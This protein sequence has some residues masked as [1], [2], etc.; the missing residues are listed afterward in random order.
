[1]HDLRQPHLSSVV[2]E[3]HGYSGDCTGTTKFCG[4]F[5]AIAVVVT[6]LCLT[7]QVRHAR[8][9]TQFGVQQSRQQAI[10]DNW[11]NRSQNPELVDAM[12]K[13]EER[14]GPIILNHKFVQALINDGGLSQ[15]EAFLVFIDQQVQSQNWVNTF[16]NPQNQSPN[17]LSRM[18]AGI[19]QHYKGGYFGIDSVK[20][21]L[22]NCPSLISKT[23]SRHNQFEIVSSNTF[24]HLVLAVC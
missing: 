14:L 15:R 22:R 24:N 9:E 21:D 16:E 20:S 2:R 23:Y 1:M 18:H 13:A 19:R 17:S 8:F 7:V 11:L 4:F 6:L 3:N 5:G 10:R 12:I